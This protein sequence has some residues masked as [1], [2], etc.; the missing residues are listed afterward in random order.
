MFT[1]FNINDT[2]RMK[3]LYKYYNLFCTKQNLFL[4]KVYQIQRP[5]LG[6][7][8]LTFTV[9]AKDQIYLLIYPSI[10]DHN[11]IEF[12]RYSEVN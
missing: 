7:K 12:I 3:F 5:L 9:K 1:R 8:Q 6:L 10:I 2:D 4:L 11:D